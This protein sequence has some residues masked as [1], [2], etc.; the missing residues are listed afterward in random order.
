M[1]AVHVGNA[2]APAF[3]PRLSRYLSWPKRKKAL[4]TQFYMQSNG[5]AMSIFLSNVSCSPLSAGD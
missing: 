3:S 5:A 4:Q 1:D 2:P